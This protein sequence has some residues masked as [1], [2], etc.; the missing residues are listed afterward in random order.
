MREK[1]GGRKEARKHTRKT[2]ILVPLSGVAVR[3]GQAFRPQHLFSDFMNGQTLV[4]LY[5]F[6]AFHFLFSCSFSEIPSVLLGI[7]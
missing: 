1:K 6:G 7:P 5:G 4:G 3:I 2:L